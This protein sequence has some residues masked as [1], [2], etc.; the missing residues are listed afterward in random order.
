MVS[1]NEET[2]IPALFAEHERA[3]AATF[4]DVHTGDL[5]PSRAYRRRFCG[6]A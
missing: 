1:L 5:I 3:N 2:I 4:W 6:E